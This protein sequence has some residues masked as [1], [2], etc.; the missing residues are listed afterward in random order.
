MSRIENVTVHPSVPIVVHDTITIPATTVPTPAREVVKVDTIPCPPVR[1]QLVLT[2]LADG[3][4][5]VIASSPD[6]RV[7]GGLDIAVK[8]AVVPRVLRWSAGP[9]Y[10]SG[11]QVG[12]FVGRETG[13]QQLLAGGTHDMR[14]GGSA[15]VGVGIRF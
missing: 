11:G 7:T 13:P 2:D 10:G 8:D 9:V 12:A 3:T 6:G 14:R 5:R 15:F 1:V 4:H